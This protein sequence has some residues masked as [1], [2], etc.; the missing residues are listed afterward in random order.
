MPYTTGKRTRQPKCKS[1]R[2]AIATASA[3]SDTSPVPEPNPDQSSHY[4]LSGSADFSADADSSFQ[5]DQH[6]GDSPTDLDFSF[7]PGNDGSSADRDEDDGDSSDSVLSP[8]LLPTKRKAVSNPKKTVIASGD[9]SEEEPQAKKARSKQVVQDLTKRELV[10]SIPRATEVG[11]QRVT[12]THA[13]SFEKALSEIHKTVGCKDVIRKP[14][15]TYRLTSATKTTPSTS[16]AS[17]TDWQGCLTDLRQAESTKRA[18][19]IIPVLIEVPA[20]YLASLAKRKGKTSASA[21]TGHGN[22]DHAGTDDDD[23]DEGLW[24]ME[25]EGK[26]LEQLQ[27]EYGH[28]QACGPTKVCKITAAGTHHHLSNNQQRAWA[29]A[30]TSGK[31]GVTLK[32]PPR[33]IAG[34]D[35]FGMFFKSVLPE[36]PQAPLFGG[37]QSFGG[38]QLPFGSMPPNMQP[39]NPY[40]MPPYP[41]MPYMPPMPPVEANPASH[42]RSTAA[43]S[44]S[45]HASTSA[46]PSSDPPD[47]GA[48]NPYPE[49]PD[50][51]RELDGYEPRRQLLDHIC[52]FE[53]LDFYHIDEIADIGTAAAL[54]DLTKMTLGNAK[55]VLGKVKDEMKRV[56]RYRRSLA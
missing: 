33:D 26:F 18:G 19:T 20:Q 35:L 38:M 54:V 23:F 9:D 45:S 50:F 34:Q 48:L 17:E 25:K 11:N 37:M 46:L 49:I 29:Q 55:F 28:C 27:N 14:E 4:D 15:L 51:L 56:D 21:N 43:P 53:Q 7:D 44:R 40:M 31:H 47:M 10:L 39:M 8:P 16:L 12:F 36:A 22:L 42:A 30:L 32:T 6:G 52:T 3:Q 13:T 41:Y 2:L 5:P 24:S 1:Q